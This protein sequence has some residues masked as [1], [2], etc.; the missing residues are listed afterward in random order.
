VLAT[1]RDRVQAFFRAPETPERTE[2]TERIE[3]VPASVW[4]LV[5]VGVA[6]L[7]NLWVLRA[8]TIPVRYPND[9][10]VHRSMVQWAADRIEE[11]H[12]PFDGWYPDLALGSSRFHHYQSLP[13]VLTGAVATLIGSERAVAWS[14]YLLLSFWPFAVYLGGRLLGW[15]RWP[16]ALAGLASPLIVSQPGLGYEY[17]SYIWRGYGTWTQLWGAWLLPLAWGFSW[18]AVDERRTYW[19][20]ALVLALTVAVHLITGYL[21]LLSLGVFVLVR[22]KDVL[23]RLGRAALIGFG[24]LLIA[25]WVVWPLLADR[26]WTVQDEFS[27]GKPFYDSFGASQVMRWLVSGEIFDRWRFP[28][29]TIL[30]AVGLVV[31]IWRFRREPRARALLGLALLSLLL[32]FGRSSLGPVVKLLPGM[33]DVFMRRFVFGVHLAG[34]YLIGLGTLRVLQLVH[35]VADRIRRRPIAV[36]VLAAAAGLLT[37]G[38]LAPAWI[39]RS[40]FAGLSGTWIHEQQDWDRTDGADAAALIAKAQRMGPGRFYAGMRSNWGPAYKVGQVPMYAVLLSESVEGVGFTRPT[41]SLSSP[42]EFRFSDVNP[43]D[44]DLFEVRYVIMP[45]GRTPPGEATRVATRG[46]HVL[47]EMPTGGYVEVVDVLPPIVADRTNLGIQ[48]SDW[49]HSPDVA[50][51][52]HPA[53]AF[54]GQPA[55][56]TT[57]AKGSPGH[58]FYQSTD[59]REGRSV[60][61]VR[62]RRTAAVLLKTSFD[63]RWQVTIDGRAAE[64]W[65]IAPSYVGVVVTPGTHRIVFQYEPFPRYDV[66]F[67]IGALT[68]A[69]FVVVPRVLR[70]RRGTDALDA[71]PTEEPALEP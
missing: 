7:F 15:D 33:G 45:D 17:G 6:V 40:R 22:P 55:A 51:G 47:W 41:W 4:P 54:E 24:S 38:A 29:L 27:R 14:L 49:L 56:P 59:L 23:R 39:E 64:P 68:L 2:R 19:A 65:M 31:G 44:Y 16:C 11:G 37:I 67:L 20:A 18:R 61:R 52:R 36:P 48:V 60:A 57:V 1:V 3:R 12:L 46:R 58:V 25:A 13:H 63:P 53:I 66:M 70:R 8:E 21:A 35:A 43:T 28:V 34:L 10:A 42:I 62:M 9:A 26:M 71:E 50:E 30:F 5:V 69:A 32:F